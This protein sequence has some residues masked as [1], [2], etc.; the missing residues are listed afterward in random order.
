MTPVHLRS[1]RAWAGRRVGLLGG[2]FNPAHEGHRHVSLLAMK[3]LGLDH[4]WWLVSP[5]NPL[6]P[7]R[8]MASLAERL[9]GARRVAKHPRIHPTAIEAELGTSFTAMTL[10]GLHRRFP[11][12]RFVWLMGADNLT[13]IPKWQNWTLIFE[14]TPVAVFNRHPYSLR[15]LNGKAAQRYR[16]NRIG[17]RRARQLPDMEPPAWV[18]FQNPLNPVSATEIRRRRNTQGAAP[19]RST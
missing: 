9:V 13:Q 15:A 16:R 18:F 17:Q 4:V 14:T 19:E 3:R 1:G 12:T 10:D 8:G 11:R 7:R 2:S 5:Q 6:K